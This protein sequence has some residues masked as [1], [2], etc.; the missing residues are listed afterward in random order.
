MKV[1]TCI[2]VCVCAVGLH[3]ACA[4]GQVDVRVRTSAGGPRIEVDGRAVPPRMFF[5]CRGTAMLPISNAWTRY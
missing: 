3:G 4:D 5:G 2:A 1:R